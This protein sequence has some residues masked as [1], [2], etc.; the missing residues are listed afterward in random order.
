MT[1]LA[2]ILIV[3]D[4]QDH[5]ELTIDALRDAGVSNPI[6]SVGTLVDARSHLAECAARAPGTALPCLIL[7]DLRLADGLGTDLLREVR[8]D[9]NLR[10]I[11]VVILTNCDDTD[12]I[13]EAYYR[14]ANSYLVKPMSFSEFRKKVRELGLYWAIINH[15]C[16]PANIS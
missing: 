10:L 8:Q 14:G 9:P 13:R 3:E 4:D 2:E 16:E 6:R 12:T 11:P 5:L 15:T 1:T 7:L